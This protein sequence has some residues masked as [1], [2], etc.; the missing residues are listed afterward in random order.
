MY[1]IT[2]CH[3]RRKSRGTEMRPLLVR[4]TIESIGRRDFARSRGMGASSETADF[5]S[6]G[7]LS[8]LSVWRGFPTPLPPNC[9]APG[10]WRRRQRR[11]SGGVRPSLH[12]YTRAVA[13]HPRRATRARASRRSLRSTLAVGEPGTRS[14]SHDDTRAFLSPFHLP[15]SLPWA[16]SSKGAFASARATG[17][18]VATGFGVRV[19]RSSFPGI[20]R[21]ESNIRDWNER[22]I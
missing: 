11:P 3:P 5:D 14:R 17:R 7:K 18:L 15:S 20:K 19:L 4:E 13:A 8:A 2:T 9:S 22:S 10:T 21:A 16:P 6:S 1:N 12:P